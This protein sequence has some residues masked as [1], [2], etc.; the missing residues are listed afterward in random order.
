LYAS[1]EA[2][3]SVI[4]KQEKDLTV[5]TCEVNQRAWDV[6]ELEGQLQE[7]EELDDITLS[8]ELEVLST[9]ETTLEHHEADLDQ[10]R[11]ALEDAR[12]QVLA[13][14]LNADTQEAGLRDQEVRL[15]AW[16]W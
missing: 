7:R 1:A 15:M 4:I 2:R 13:H 16:E 6:E 14:E 11:K 10:E 8:H 12:A 9:H 3:A 5:R